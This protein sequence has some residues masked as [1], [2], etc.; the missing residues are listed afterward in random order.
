MKHTPGPWQ[1]THLRE[2]INHINRFRIGTGE[3]GVIAVTACDHS[4]QAEP[5]ARLIAAA[6]ELLEA[7]KAFVEWQHKADR[8]PY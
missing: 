8:I 2:G 6:P 3:F 1:T 4:E 7:L 5:N